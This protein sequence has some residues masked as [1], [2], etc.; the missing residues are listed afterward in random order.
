MKLQIKNQQW[1][2]LLASDLSSKHID[3]NPTVSPDVL[4]WSGEKLSFRTLK[5]L[6]DKIAIALSYFLSDQ[7]KAFFKKQNIDLYSLRNEGSIQWTSHQ[8]LKTYLKHDFFRDF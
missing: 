2:W 3:F 4:L 5:Q 8:G 6:D 1:L 7:R